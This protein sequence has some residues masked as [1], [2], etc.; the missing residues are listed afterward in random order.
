MDSTQ[1]QHTNRQYEEDLRALRT[2]LLKM[3]GLV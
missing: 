2:S 1:P 3:G